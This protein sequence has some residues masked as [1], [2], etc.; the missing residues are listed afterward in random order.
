M[1]RGCTRPEKV[2]NKNSPGRGQAPSMNPNNIIPLE[3]IQIAKPCRA[4]WNHM[5]GDQRAR[6]CGSCHKNVYDIS[7]MTRAD[8]H[9]LIV[10]KEGNVCVRLYRRPDGT[11][12][13]SDC[14][15]G[16]REVAHPMWWTLAGFVALMASGAAVWSQPAATD[17]HA[18]ANATPLV[19]RART[20]PLVGAVVNKVSPQ[21]QPQMMMGDIAVIAP[22]T[23]GAIAP[24]PA[25]VPQPTNAPL[26]GKPAT[27]N[28]TMGAPI[29]PLPTVA[30]TVAPTVEPT[31]EPLMGEVA[32]ICE[33]APQT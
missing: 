33:K 20:W 23:M 27:N 15:V 26:M 30:S 1:P 22:P 28:A 2:G 5:T 16:K 31:P 6:F 9:N 10:E 12:I 7:Q 13:T 18:R 25:A 3:A 19:D 32:P 8:A 21:P 11:V 29:A 14:P 4:D 24:Q 17:N